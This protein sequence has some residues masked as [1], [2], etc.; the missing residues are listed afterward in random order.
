MTNLVT[1][2]FSWSFVIGV[3]VG[4]ALNRAAVLLRVCWLDRHQPLPDGSHRSK[5]RAVM[6]DARWFAGAIAISV[7]AWSVFQ[8]QENTNQAARIT[9][10]A[11]VFAEK[12]REC[13]KILIQSITASRKLSNEYNALSAQQRDAVSDWISTLLSPPPNIAALDGADPVRQNWA[14]GVTAQFHATIQRS[15]IEQARNDEQRRAH[16]LPDPDCG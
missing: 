10:E 1:H 5:L 12:T 4:F 3:V 13:Q 7:A 14:I 16:Q 8:T 9:V 2:L 11:K 6:I 15:Q